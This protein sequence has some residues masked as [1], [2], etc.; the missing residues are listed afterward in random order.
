MYEQAK[1]IKQIIDDAQK[2]VIVQADNPDADSLGS[3]LAL[4]H[5]LGDLGKEVYLYSGV[6]TPGYLR[7]MAGW[8]RIQSELPRQFD[9]SII[10][11]ASTMTLLEKLTASGQQGWLAA[12]PCIVLDHHETVDNAVPFSTVVVNDPGRASAGELI[13]LLCKQLQWPVST[14]AQRYLMSSILGDTQGLTNQLASAETY[15]I[16]AEFIDNGV[17]RPALEEQRREYGKMPPEIYRYKADLIKRT[18]LAADGRLASVVIPQTEI[19]HYSPLYNPAPLIQNDMLQTVGVMVA[20]VFKHYGDGKVTA[21]IRCNSLAPIGGQLAKHF[22]GGGHAL[23]SGFKVTDGR[24]L[25]DIK[26]D[27][28]KLA[29]ELLDKES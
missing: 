11:D 12:K 8:D 27:C 1:T 9:A 15:R 6:D 14:E 25:D 17:D 4:E 3:A 13:Y 24:S 2:V 21:A 22:G 19:N 18:E 5:I 20:I 16:L 23:A 26:A 28:L 29:A 10:V 7:Y